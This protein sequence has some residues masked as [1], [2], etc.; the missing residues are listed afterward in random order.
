MGSDVE[1]I[2]KILATLHDICRKVTKCFKSHCSL[3]QLFF[4]LRN[5]LFLWVFF[6][7]NNMIEEHLPVNSLI[8]LNMFKS[9]GIMSQPFV[10]VLDIYARYVLF[11]T[12]IEFTKVGFIFWYTG[13]LIQDYTGKLIKVEI[14]TFQLHY[15]I[16]LKV[17]QEIYQSWIW[18]ILKSICS[19]SQQL[20]FSSQKRMITMYFSK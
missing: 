18:N 9:N 10:L 5:I 3:L 17:L 12:I 11:Q 6:Q 20:I 7:K 15:I 8:F 13:K 19:M 16:D 4:L 1:Y 14:Q 2:H